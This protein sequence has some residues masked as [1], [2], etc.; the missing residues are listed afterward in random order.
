MKIDPKNLNLVV[1]ID[2]DNGVVHVHSAPIRREVFK[3]YFLILSKTL[4]AIYA[5]GLHH[6][7]G[8]RIAAMMLQK[9]AEEAGVWE[10]VRDGL[11]AEIRRLSNA[12][13]LTADGWKSV[14]L[15]MCVAQG[16]LTVDEV[17]EAEGF[18]VFFTCI[19]HIHRKNEI[20]AFLQPMREMWEVLTTSLNSTEYRASLPISTETETF[21]LTTPASLVPG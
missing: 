2:T 15:E 9:L 1:P 20:S 5:E 17:E 8:P 12:Q 4:N 6:V 19:Y 3:Q 21:S 14:P 13:V 18:I 11:M 10:S 7:T 16:Y